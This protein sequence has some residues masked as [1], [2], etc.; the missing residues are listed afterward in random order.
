MPEPG[1]G[2]KLYFMPR[3]RRNRI[4]RS[5]SLNRNTPGSGSMPCQIGFRVTAEKFFLRGATC[6]SIQRSKCSTTYS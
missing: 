3:S 5:I 4:R 6:R 2:I 1:I